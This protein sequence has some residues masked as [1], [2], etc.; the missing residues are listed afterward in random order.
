MSNIV[1]IIVKEYIFATSTIERVC[2]VG[3]RTSEKVGIKTNMRL[4][5]SV[6]YSLFKSNSFIK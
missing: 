6:N 3:I 4:E 2:N 1:Y 5:K